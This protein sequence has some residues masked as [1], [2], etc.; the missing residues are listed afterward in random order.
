MTHKK[1]NVNKLPKQP[2]ETGTERA[3]EEGGLPWFALLSTPNTALHRN[4]SESAKQYCKTILLFN[5]LFICI[6]LN[7]KSMLKTS[8]KCTVKNRIV[9]ISYSYW[10][11]KN[12]DIIK[13]NN[14]L[15]KVPYI[16]P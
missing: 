4:Q 16:N 15:Y 13:E 6:H 12:Y 1:D 3:R 10:Q 2:V 11:N 7:K 14:Y 8:E 5:L 9:L